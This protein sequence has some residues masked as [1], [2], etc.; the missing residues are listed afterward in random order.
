MINDVYNKLI[1]KKDEMMRKMLLTRTEWAQNHANA[2]KDEWIEYCPEKP[3]ELPVIG[4]D[5]GMWVSETKTGAVFAVDAVAVYGQGMNLELLDS[6]AELGFLSPGND[7]KDVVSLFM[8]IMEMKL[9][10]RGL[11]GLKNANAELVL[12]DG[13]VVKKGERSSYVR[14]A[15]A[16]V[17]LEKIES[18]EESDE[19]KAYEK[20]LIEHRR[21]L[22][23]LL[24]F[25]EKI[26]WISKKSRSTEIFG[27]EFP[28]SVIL[29][30]LTDS[31]GYTKPRPIHMRYLPVSMYYSFVR[32]RRGSKVLRVDFSGDEAFLRRVISILRSTETKG[33]PMQLLEAHRKARFSKADVRR[34]SQVLKLNLIKGPQWVPKSLK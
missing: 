27:S 16:A 23:D 19:K 17:N 13:S 21:A 20:A 5:G 22:V 24:S 9:A 11:N 32:L 33:Y 3:V 10:L 7:A 2:I 34:L 18:L 26:I 30:L 14:T 25:R 28:D 8:E 4:V 29:D 15:E 1:Q 12:M 6:M 31:C